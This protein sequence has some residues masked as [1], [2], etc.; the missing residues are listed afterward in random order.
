LAEMTSLV[1]RLLAM[2][3]CSES[4]GSKGARTDYD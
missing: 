2:F 3:R 4:F 1:N